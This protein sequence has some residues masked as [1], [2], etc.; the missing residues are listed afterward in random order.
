M[1]AE[2][3]LR[4]LEGPGYSRLSLPGATLDYDEC[5]PNSSC[6]SPEGFEYS[7][8]SLTGAM[9]DHDWKYGGLEEL[10]RSS[11]LPDDQRLDASCRA[12]LP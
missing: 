11:P 5:L 12:Q 1:S 10:R 4:K 7:R 8:L 2:Y 3:V 9:L 6:A